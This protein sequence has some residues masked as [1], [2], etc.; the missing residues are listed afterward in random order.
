MKEVQE[1][2]ENLPSTIKTN[3]PDH[4]NL[5]EFRLIVCPTEDSLWRDGKFEFQISIS[6]DYNMIPPKVKCVTKILHPNISSEFDNLSSNQAN[7]E[8][9]KLSIFQLLAMSASRSYDWIQL[10]EWDGCQREDSK[11]LSSASIHCS[12]ISVISTIRS[13]LNCPR[14]TRRTVK[15]SNRK[16]VNTRF[17]MREASLMRACWASL[18][19]EILSKRKIISISTISTRVCGE[20]RNWNQYLNIIVHLKS[21][22]VTLW[23]NVPRFLRF[24]N[25]LILHAHALF[26]Y[27]HSLTYC[28][29]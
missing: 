25:E 18:L 8:Y 23:I 7:S 12:R 21:F 20:C 26:D 28:F 16:F 15:K 2:E 11:T 17:T 9:Y 6:E 4:N 3:F 1:M 29:V 24:R 14:S 5:A 13:T 19:C 10:M 22:D 27:F